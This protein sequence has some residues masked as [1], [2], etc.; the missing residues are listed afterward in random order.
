MDHSFYELDPSDPRLA[1]G[2][3]T[4]LLGDPEPVPA[5]A[6]GWLGGAGGIYSTPADLARWN[7]ALVGGKF[8][9]PESYALMTSPRGLKNGKVT[10]YGCGLSIKTQNGR[11][12]LSHNGA[13]SGFNTWNGVVPSTRSAVVVMSNLEGG[14]GPLPGQLFS[15][16]LRET[17]S[18]PAVAGRAA[19]DVAR[20]IFTE[21]ARGK[22][23]RGQFAEEFNQYLTD[24]RIAAAARR[25]KAYGVPTHAEMLGTHERG[26]MEVSMTRLTFSKTHLRVQMYREPN[27]RIQQYFVMRD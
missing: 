22:V 27:G 1:T 24:E 12:V 20:A 18:V 10:D 23:D 13:V 25:F 26:G 8:L 21:M 4:F 14:Y 5:E 3:A 11:V 16:L 17:P 7:L 9:K 2:Y 6:R 15:L 19:A